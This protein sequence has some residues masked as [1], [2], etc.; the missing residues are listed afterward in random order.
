M[1]LKNKL[2][3]FKFAHT[4]KKN[5]CCYDAHHN[6]TQQNDTQHND[7]QHYDTQHNNTQHK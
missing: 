3:Y 1:K 2:L 7:I 4:C 5:C 6:D